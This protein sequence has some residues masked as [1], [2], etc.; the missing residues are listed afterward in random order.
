MARPSVRV[1]FTPLEIALDL[2]AASSFFLIATAFFRLWPAV[3]EQVPVHFDVRGVADAFGP[4]ST[5]LALPVL[6]GVFYVLLTFLRFVPHWHNYP[7]AVTASNAPRLYRLS[8]LLVAWVK[9]LVLW[10]MATL[11]WQ[12][13]RAA[14]TASGQLG[15]PHPGWFVAGVGVVLAGYILALRRK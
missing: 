7:V 10:L 8:I 2:A 13:C 5:L 3:P 14:V 4:R 15:A 1:P 9:V 12:V 11:F 6:W